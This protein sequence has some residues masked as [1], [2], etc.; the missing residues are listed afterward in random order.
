MRVLASTVGVYFATCISHH[1]VFVVCTH[2]TLTAN[3]ETQIV[4]L[5]Q[6]YRRGLLKRFVYL[7]RL[8]ISIAGRP[9][10]ELMYMSAAKYQ[11]MFETLEVCSTIS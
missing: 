2:W 7:F 3:D 9:H 6:R 5:D 1:R 11:C 4:D 10:A 8:E